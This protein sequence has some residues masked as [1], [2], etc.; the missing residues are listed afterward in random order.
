MKIAVFFV[1]FFSL[2]SSQLQAQGITA[3]LLEEGTDKPIPFATIQFEKNRGVI[4][5]EDGVFKIPDSD[6]ISEISISSIGYEIKTLS[7]EDM[8]PVIYLKPATIELTSVFISDKNLEA[9]DILERA[10][11]AVPQN[12]EFD[13]RKKR[14]F[15]RRSYVDHVNDFKLDIEESTI[16]GL[17]Q[18]FMDKII[19]K[20]PIYV[21]SYR[22]YL[23]DFYGNYDDQKVQLLKVANLENPLNEESVEDMV[24]RFEKILQDNVTEGTFLKI[25][26]GILAVKMDADEV[27]E[28]IEE[29]KSSRDPE[30]PEELEKQQKKRLE[31]TQNSAKRSIGRLMDNMFWEED[32]VLD[33]FEKSRKYEFTNEGFININNSIAYV[34]AFEPKR[35]ADFKG[36][37]YI[38]TEDFGIHRLDYENV[39]NLKSFSL[40]GIRTQDHLYS[41]KLIF[42]K[43][44]NGKY[45]PRFIEQYSGSKAE[46]ERP[47]TLLVKKEKGF[48]FKKKLEEVDMEFKINTTNLNKTELVVYEDEALL[49]SEFKNF[50]NSMD[51]DFRTFKEYDPEFWS[52]YN[53][54][55]PNAAI[56]EF[57]ALETD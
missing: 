32:I 57:T 45:G 31:N 47:F 25:K 19:S 24:K 2:L 12:Y 20:V 34:L 48:I 8:E 16:E 55:E 35:G 44:E 33:V 42:N 43:G 49:E 27:N 9:E 23:G 54:I 3:T 22:E 17:D 15:L 10:I 36:K 50:S 18:P 28:G 52:G 53:I 5:N 21:D 41:G 1:F 46:I 30:T 4:S 38:D 56:R 26:S 29:S 13:L 11:A 14:F 7:L 40:L 37:V 39:K 6:K 51:F